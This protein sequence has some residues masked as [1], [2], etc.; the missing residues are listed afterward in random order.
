M[1]PCNEIGTT[2]AQLRVPAACTATSSAR[3]HRGADVGG[4][5][6]SA[7]ALR[8]PHLDDRAIAQ[9]GRRHPSQPP[10]AWVDPS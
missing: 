4:A 6:K 1:T 5:H 7:D 9:R 2:A 10:W 8:V 3:Q